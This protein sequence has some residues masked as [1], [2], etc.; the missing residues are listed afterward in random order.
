MSTPASPFHLPCAAGGVALPAWKQELHERLREHR[1]RSGVQPATSPVLAESRGTAASTVAARVAERYRQA[2]SY[3]D[4]LQASAEAQAAEK[5]AEKAAEEASAR[6]I[7]Q[8]H[9]A[10]DRDAVTAAAAPAQPRQDIPLHATRD[11]ILDTLHPGPVRPAPDKRYPVAVE[12][13]APLPVRSVVP[14]RRPAER[15]A[16]ALV[17]AFAEA[18]VH[19]AQSLPAKLI[20][21]PRELIAARKQRPRLAEGPLHDD[22]GEQSPAAALRIFE[23]SMDAPTFKPRAEQFSLADAPPRTDAAADAGTIREEVS[24][25]S[26]TPMTHDTGPEPI[27]RTAFTWEQAPE[28]VRKQREGT[29][30]SSIELEAHPEA[31]HQHLAA[32]QPEHGY[33]AE[34]AP[35]LDDLATVGDRLMAALVDTSLVFACFLLSVLVFVFCTEQLPTGR[36]ALL[37]GALFLGV[38]AAFYGWLFLRFGGGSTPGMRYAHIALCTFSD[39]NPT[40]RQLQGRVPATALALLPLGL[41]VLWAL[42][43][44]DKLGWQD[45]LTRTYQRSYR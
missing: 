8:T 14:Q 2:P 34:A 6:A 33:D 38:L 11:G 24:I 27:R 13:H 17:D 43:D 10:A 7:R 30:W 5:A 35:L 4:V 18:T 44:E 28:R 37:G 23:V 45:R 19:A 16:P 26:P 31:A 15:R 3:R 36:A 1:L 42:L 20:E 21:F 22:A 9:R 41:G 40:S 12:H 39:E 29:G 25:A 32:R